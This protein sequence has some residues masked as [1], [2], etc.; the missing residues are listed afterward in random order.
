[1]RNEGQ[2]ASHLSEEYNEYYPSILNLYSFILHPHK[3]MRTYYLLQAFAIQFVFFYFPSFKR[4]GVVIVHACMHGWILMTYSV[5]YSQA[6]TYDHY[7]PSRM[8]DLRNEGGKEKQNL[9]CSIEGAKKII[10]WFT[11]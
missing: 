10:A 1:M 9:C 4:T 6:F 3:I 2:F 11:R 5:F 7:A 8:T